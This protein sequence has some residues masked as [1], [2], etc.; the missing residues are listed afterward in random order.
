ML[1]LGTRLTVATVAL[2]VS[3]VSSS[4]SIVPAPGK[5][6]ENRVFAF[7]G[8]LDSCN[9]TKR[10]AHESALLNEA[11]RECGQSP[12]NYTLRE[13]CGPGHAYAIDYTCY[14]EHC[15]FDPKSEQEHTEMVMARIEKAQRIHEAYKAR[16]SFTIFRAMLPTM[17]AVDFPESHTECLNQSMS[18]P[19]VP[20]NNSYISRH[21]TFFE[22]RKIM[23]E[24]IYSIRMDQI[25]DVVGHLL[26]GYNCVV[27]N[28]FLYGWFNRKHTLNFAYSIMDYYGMTYS[29]CDFFPELKEPTEDFAA[30]SHRRCLSLAF[31]PHFEPSE[32]PET[33]LLEEPQILELDSTPKSRTSSS[34]SRV[35]SSANPT[36][37]SQI[38]ICILAS[39]QGCIHCT[40]MFIHRASWCFYMDKG[41]VL[42]SGSWWRFS[43][44]N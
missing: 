15:I 38:K 13:S 33:D 10:C 31:E 40:I 20:E 18:E 32:P 6:W 43:S 11:T 28:S 41:M 1:P 30:E 19:R 34:R 21:R 12:E 29:G 17:D 5:C 4:T 42:L 39:L 24:V 7:F 23:Q 36:Y 14:A 25:P 22:F 35:E 37:G 44:H 9:A 3:F 27:M 8:S 2:L 16:D 26:N